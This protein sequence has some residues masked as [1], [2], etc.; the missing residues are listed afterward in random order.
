MNREQAEKFA[1]NQRGNPIT[2]KIFKHKETEQY[3]TQ[4]SIMEIGEYN[5]V[6]L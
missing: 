3:E 5:E 1:E 2:T 6:F 4:I